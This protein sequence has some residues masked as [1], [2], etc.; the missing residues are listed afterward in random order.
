M[1]GTR[2]SFDEVSAHDHPIARGEPGGAETGKTSRRG[3]VVPRR[4]VTKAGEGG[5]ECNGRD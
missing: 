3:S 5:G 2:T 4:C 1:E